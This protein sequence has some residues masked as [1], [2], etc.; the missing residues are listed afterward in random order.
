MYFPKRKTSIIDKES[1]TKE[2]LIK[3]LSSTLLIAR[4]TALLID[5]KE[6]ISLLIN[7]NL[8]Y[9]DGLIYL[10][11]FKGVISTFIYYCFLSTCFTCLTS[12]LF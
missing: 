9:V 12:T 10:L 3:T 1:I 5:L 4:I 2:Y 11:F 7:F 8:Y 6:K